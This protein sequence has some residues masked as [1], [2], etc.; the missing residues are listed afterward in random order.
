MLPAAGFVHAQVV[1]I[2]FLTVGQRGAA[3]VVPNLAEAVAR[4]RTVVV[5]DEN[6][7]AFVFQKLFQGALGVLQ[8][9]GAENIRPDVVVDTANLI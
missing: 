5:C 7:L 2:Q 9:I 3:G 4:H 1:D 8:G 6:G